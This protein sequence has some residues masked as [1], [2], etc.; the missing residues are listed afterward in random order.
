MK[1]T[2]LQEATLPTL[3]GHSR[4]LPQIDNKVLD[5]IVQCSVARSKFNGEGAQSSIT[6]DKDI[7]ARRSRV[8]RLSNEQVFAA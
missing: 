7:L 3:T 6:I 2:E 8:L 5:V 4:P 1:T